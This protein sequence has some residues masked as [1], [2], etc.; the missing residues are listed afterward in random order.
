MDVLGIEALRQMM[1]EMGG[2]GLP[3]MAHLCV[4]ATEVEAEAEV[5]IV[6]NDDAEYLAPNGGHMI[7]PLTFQTETVMIL[8]DAGLRTQN[9]LKTPETHC[10]IK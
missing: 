7:A 4:V 5:A 6:M 1:M 9:F 8:E 2:W 10:F 3:K